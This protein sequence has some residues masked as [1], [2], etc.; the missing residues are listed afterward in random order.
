MRQ[1]RRVR[2]TRNQ[3]QAI[4]ARQADSGLSA[5]AFCQAE[6]IGYASFV[7]WRRRFAERSEKLSPK[8]TLPAFIELTSDVP[9]SIGDKP[10][11]QWHIELD[12]APG[13]Q[14]RIA[15]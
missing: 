15:R 2:R 1:Q 11:P 6:E 9:A 4:V 7:Q 5:R 12:L 8:Q 13:V 3:W 14:L 10:E